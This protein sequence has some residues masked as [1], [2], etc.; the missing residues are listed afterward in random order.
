MRIGL[1]VLA[2][3]LAGLP[4]GAQNISYP[5]FSS[6]TGLT[7]N[8]S[9]AQAANQLELNPSV[10]SSKGSVFA[11]NPVIVTDGFETTFEFQVTQ[12]VSG[13]GDGLS[14][15]IH[16]DPR[17]DTALGDHAAQM[18]YGRFVAAAVGTGLTES[19]VIEFDT[20]ANGNQN[21]ISGNSV[22]VHTNGSGENEANESFSIG[23]AN[24]V[25]NMSDG[26]LHT[27]RIRYVPG[28]LEVYVDDLVN[29]VLTVPYDFATGGTWTSSGMP[30][31]P[32]VLFGGGTAFVGFTAGCGGSFERHLLSS[33]DFQS[34]AHPCYGG[35][36]Q[37]GVGGIAEIFT[38][39]GE[40]GG[41]DR[42]VKVGIN[43][44]INFHLAQPPVN[45]APAH[46][47]IVGAIGLNVPIITNT[48]FG[49][50]CLPIAY[51]NP[52]SPVLF[53]LA[54]NLI[55][56][57]STPPLIPFASPTP[58]NFNLPAGIPF[59]A[60]FTLQGAVIEDNTNP[61]AVAI[62]NGIIVEVALGP[63]PVLSTVSPAVP[64]AGQTVTVTGS[65]FQPGMALSING[66][67]E[68]LTV[69]DANTATFVAV[70][71]YPC[72]APLVIANPDGQFTTGTISPSPT[73]SLIS[74]ST[75]PA[76]GGG[77]F[78]IAGQNFTAG[79]MTVTFGSTPATV[80]SSSASSIIGN[81]PP[82][83]V[84]P[85]TVTIVRPDGCLATTTYTY[86]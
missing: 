5:D 70:G 11:T 47:A 45:P 7:L 74:P 27:A 2:L 43:A 41:L 83:A 3:A 51:F 73:I 42:T 56:L 4:L 78:V 15:A 52:T 32:P 35:T 77:I 17:L 28:T 31:P 29:P 18:G 81:A 76:A 26:L 61:N 57:P 13:G 59:P 82:G 62:T 6:V 60:V 69:V 44:P 79:A 37:D 33:W 1:L 85:V 21:D 22:S 80:S 9:A 24:V 53:V 71:G 48:V 19:I 23:E 30:V 38:V 39:N 14:F 10:I 8:G 36:V 58:W 65:G 12:L 67:A 72:D 46:F 40:T 84:G 49:D 20:F 16:A 54:D 55:Q 75:G 86:Q 63:P 50:I 25:P 66:V 64:L 34:A 68:A